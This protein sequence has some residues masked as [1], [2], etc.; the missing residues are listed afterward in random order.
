MLGSLRCGYRY[1][2]GVRQ[3]DDREGLAM[4]P[5]AQ[6]RSLFALRWSELQERRKKKKRG[7]LAC[8]ENPVPP[9]LDLVDQ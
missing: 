1:P 4:P 9:T 5:H 3:L 8:E 6:R 7:V 2:H